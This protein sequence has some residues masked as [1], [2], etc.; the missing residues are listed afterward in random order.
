MRTVKV[1]DPV[2]RLFH[3]GLALTV[4]GS[5]LTSDEDALVP[6]H[7]KLGLAVVALVVTRLAWG[8][9]G[10]GPARFSSFVKRPREVLAYARELL[11]GRPTLHLSHNPL[12]GAMVVALLAVL[13]GLAA[14]GALVYAGPEFQGPLSGVLSKGGAHAVKEVHEGL[15]AA[16]LVLVGLH[17]A[18][19]V[20]SSLLERQNL[21]LGMITGRKR[22]P[23]GEAAPAPAPSWLPL[24]RAAGAATAIALGAA[25]AFGLGFILGVPSRAAAGGDVSRGLLEEYAAAAKAA[26]PGFAGFSAAEGR[27]I[28]TAEHVQAGQK[29]SC[30]TCHTDDP[31]RTGRTPIGKVVEPLAPAANPAR[32]T[33][34]ADVEKWF[35]RNCTQVLG[36][37]CTPEEKGHFVTYLLSP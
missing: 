16:L 34:R 20:G 29:V 9:L 31:R 27:R 3:W 23:D 36:R 30:A 2:V 8:L 25:A 1:W 21:V 19:V 26:R 15:S 18:G 28:Y 22:A 5:F 10:P 37:E 24:A 33:N 6:T 13:A 35:R 14:T 7:V 11:R 32:L 12:G 4:L 17:V